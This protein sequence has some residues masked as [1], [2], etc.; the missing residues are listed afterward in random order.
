MQGQCLSIVLCP[1]P[2]LLQYFNS[3]QCIQ[4]VSKEQPA[5]EGGGDGVPA[6]CTSSRASLSQVPF[7]A[8]GETAVSNTLEFWG[9]LHKSP[10]PHFLIIKQRP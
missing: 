10:T 5:E 6:P 7:S 9:S 4:M 8:F 3:A 1:G 2:T